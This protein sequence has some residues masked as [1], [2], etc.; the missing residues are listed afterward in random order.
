MEK[1]DQPN[2]YESGYVSAATNNTMEL[3]AGI[4]AMEHILALGLQR[5]YM[6]RIWSDSNY[7]VQGMQNHRHIWAMTDFE[8][9][10]AKNRKLWKEAHA[11]AEKIPVIR[12]RW[13][14][15]HAGHQWNEHCDRMAA[16]AVK[17]GNRQQG[18]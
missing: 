2:I 3:T 1:Y 16:A 9:E 13:L 7:V 8:L 18:E 5:K 17:F 15:G 6:I 14:K 10:P 12:F 4:K 11:V